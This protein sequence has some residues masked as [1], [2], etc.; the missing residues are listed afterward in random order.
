[1][2]RSAMTPPG[3]VRLDGEVDDTETRRT[4]YDRRASAWTFFVLGLLVVW[5][6]G[7]TGL[8]QDA[9]AWTLVG[10]AGVLIGAAMVVVGLV[11]FQQPRP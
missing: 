11:R 7:F 1:M 4:A 2:V 5:L 6:V 9:V 8:G 3:D 10:Y